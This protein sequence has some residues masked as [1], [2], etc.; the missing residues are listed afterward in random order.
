VFADSD[1]LRLQRVL[2]WEYLWRSLYRES[3]YMLWT[4][5]RL[6]DDKLRH[7]V[8]RLSERW[9]GHVGSCGKR[10]TQRDQAEGGRVEQIHASSG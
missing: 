8:R 1:P 3:D 7:P 6:Q 9:E 2:V 4:E 10:E 5:H